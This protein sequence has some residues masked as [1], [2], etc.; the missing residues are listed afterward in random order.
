[1]ERGMSDEVQAT[2]LTP[3]RRSIGKGWTATY[4]LDENRWHRVR[5]FYNGRVKDSSVFRPGREDD[6]LTLFTATT[7]SE[8]C[9]KYR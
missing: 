2:L 6:A 4:D 1:M 8:L 9:R 5:F 7:L 3:M